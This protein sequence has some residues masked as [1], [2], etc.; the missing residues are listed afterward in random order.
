MR[1]SYSPTIYVGVFETNHRTFKAPERMFDDERSWPGAFRF[2]P[3]QE[4]SQLTSVYNVLI[5]AVLRLVRDPLTVCAH[6]PAGSQMCGPSRWCAIF[7]AHI[8]CKLIK[9]T[10]F[11]GDISMCSSD[12]WIQCALTWA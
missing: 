6:G 11:T 10:P 4:V 12:Y 2:A 3:R 9:A 1:G 7:H 8:T 5:D